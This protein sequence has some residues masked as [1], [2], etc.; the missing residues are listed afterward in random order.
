[1]TEYKDNLLKLWIQ[2]SKSFN[3]DFEEIL[4]LGIYSDI[5]DIM[6]ALLIVEEARQEQINVFI[7]DNV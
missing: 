2:V 3:D 6:N 7:H 4:E 1:M 5:S